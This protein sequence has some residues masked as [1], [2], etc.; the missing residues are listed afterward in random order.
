MI[1][2]F[3]DY[4][5]DALIEVDIAIIGAGAAG[6]TMALELEGSGRSV[7]VLESGGLDPES[8]PEPLLDGDC[9]GVPY[10]DL[11]TVRA[12]WLG[13]TTNYWNNRC[14]PQLP[15]D[16]IPRHWVPLSGWPVRAEE[17]E[18]FFRRA[19]AYPTL[20]P[21]AYEPEE[22]PVDTSK[23]IHPDPEF[24]EHVVY[25][26]TRDPTRF[27]IRYVDRLRDLRDVQVLLHA[28]ALELVPNESVTAVD[29]VEL[30]TLEGKRGT[31]RAKHYVLACGGLENARL[32]LLSDRRTPQG[33]GNAN[34][35]VGRYFMEHL[36]LT[37]AEGYT[38]PGTN[39]L[40]A[41]RYHR[42]PPGITILNFALTRR[43]QERH[44]LLGAAFQF[45]E[46]TG[47]SELIEIA[48]IREYAR[49]TGCR[50]FS[51]RVQL[52]LEPLPESRVTL[53]E[54]RDVF[55]Q[56]KVKLDWRLSEIPKK[57]MRFGTERLAA[58]LARLGAARLHVFEWL[59]TD[60]ANWLDYSN[61]GHHHMGTTRM[62]D[63]P[64]TGVVD[65]NGTVHGLSNLHATGTS[66]FSCG[67]FQN[68][69][70]TVIA[71]SIRLADHLRAALA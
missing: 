70:L 11:R 43:I 5:P 14:R 62:S 48:S 34:D 8:N 40:G 6:I 59:A 30:S 52:E 17:M 23:M 66:V 56:P 3:R 27:G 54:R 45:N 61:V 37:V 49:A 29:R 4:E 55:D 31:L 44:G 64:R 18:P 65:R 9:V 60:A 2:D 13:G 38:L 20:G 39:W 71:L 32:L 28:I 36:G 19:H 22:T 47:S 53:S 57:T 50:T 15:S 33:L 46:S 68:P 58:E 41:Y 25:H 1:R 12:R 42:Y 10:P 69:T 26:D 67:G 51:V 7:C 35:Q 21:Y 16:Y 63:D 24:F